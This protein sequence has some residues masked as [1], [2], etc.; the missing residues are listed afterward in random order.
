MTEPKEPSREEVAE[1]EEE[2]PDSPMLI[3]EW[4]ETDDRVDVSEDPQ[5]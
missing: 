2:E 3:D 5:D 1:E 4:D